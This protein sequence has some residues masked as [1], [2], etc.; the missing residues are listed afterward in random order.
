M[1]EAMNKYL[2]SLCVIF[3]WNAQSLLAQDPFI[4]T[5]KTD[6]PGASN[7][8][9]ITIP[10]I[11]GGGGYNY[12]VEWGDGTS[13]VGVTMTAAPT[14]TYASP[15]TYTVTITGDFPRFLFNNDG[16]REKLLTVEQWGNIVWNAVSFY[17]CTNLEV[18]ATDA[19][20]LSS[21]TSLNGIFR[22]CPNFNTDVNHWNTSN[23]QFMKNTFSGATS[24]N[25]DI[26]NWDV[27]K[28]TDMEG[29]FFDADAFNQDIGNWDVGLVKTTQDMFGNTSSFNQ[30]I[31]DWDVSSL[32]NMQTMFAGSQSFN[33]D[34]GDW[35]V[36]LVQ[37]MLATFNFASVFNQDIGDWNVSDVTNM[38]VMFNASSFNQDIRG[39]NVAKVKN[40]SNMFSSSPFNQDV[41][42]W[43]VSEVTNMGDM[44]DN[45]SLSTTNYD[46]ILS[47]WSNRTVQNDVPFGAAG[48][49][50]CNGA[51]GRN[52]LE[53]A[54]WM[55]DDGD[56]VCRPL[57]TTWKTDNAGPSGDNQITISTT[58]GGYSYDVSWEEV[59][60]EAGNNGVE[61]VGQTENYTVT[62]PSSGT[63]RVY[64]SGDFPR[65]YFNFGGDKDKL[66]TIEQWGDIE[67][68]S[69]ERAFGGCT[70]VTSTATDAPNL[71]SVTSLQRCFTSCSNFNGAIGNW[72]TDNVT[73]M[74]NMFHSASSFNQ[75]ISSWNTDN[76]TNMQAM[77]RE[78]TSFNQD[79]SGWNTTNVE[80]THYMF[81]QAS[82]FNQ[83]ISGW[84][85]E[86]ARFINSM[87]SE[88]TSFDQ[89]IGDWD[90]SSAE[91]MDEMFNGATSFN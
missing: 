63:Y 54:G 15:G 56:M 3:L 34:I 4:T 18:A 26:S 24:F 87:F 1:Y 40:M 31:G 82:S 77:F 38:S 74:W 29:M 28:V 90:V 84:N 55:I 37:N 88:A 30:D 75:N 60:N 58:G 47:G 51:E 41:G 70:N 27:S 83:D 5:W 6:N 68:S 43:N 17:G 33:Q 62:F 11:G 85:L 36:S 66:M 35:D 89:D 50:Y 78:A 9:Q 57:I 65:I 80:F 61:P 23:I 7:D 44:F 69:M 19:P 2:L 10:T 64:I 67:W 45:S 42:D 22:N 13:D 20:N 76:V 39:W 21:S 49:D 12:T 52:T 72:N 91:R 79:I 81:Y 73:D 14:H 86:N 46:N 71:N 32:I 59:G 25:Q 16:D 48:I 53:A 8:D